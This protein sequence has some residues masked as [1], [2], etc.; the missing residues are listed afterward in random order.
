MFVFTVP[1]RTCCELFKFHIHGI[2]S[3]FCEILSRFR[4]ILSR[5]RFRE[6]ASIVNITLYYFAKVSILLS[7]NNISHSRNSISFNVWCTRCMLYGGPE[8]TY[9]QLQHMN[10]RPGKS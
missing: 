10:T 3:R 4:E 6:I 5:F 7:R 9:T 8:V 1:L 2:L